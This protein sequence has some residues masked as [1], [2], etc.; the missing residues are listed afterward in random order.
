MFLRRLKHLWM[1]MLPVLLLVACGG[2]SAPAPTGLSVK[3]GESSALVHW[4]ME[5]GVEYWLFYAPKSVAPTTT[6]MSRGWTG[7]TGGNVVIRVQSPTTVTGLSNDIEYVF[8][9]NGRTN[10]GPGGPGA[11]L[12]SATPRLAGSDWA[13]TAAPIAP[14]QPLRAVAQGAL[15]VAGGTSGTLITSSDLQVWT[16]RDQAAT[17]SNLNAGAFLT[18]YRF[19]GDNGTILTSTDAINWTLQAS[20]TS[21]NLYGIGTNN[22]NTAVAVGAN[23]TILTSIDGLTWAS[24]RSNTQ[25]DL[26]GVTYSSAGS[27]LWIAVGA[28]GTILQSADALTWT[29]ID[30][31]TTADLRGVQY[32]LLPL[33]TGATVATGVFVAVGSNGT[34][35]NSANGTAWTRSAAPTPAPTAMTQSFAQT[36]WNA[37][38]YGR[39][40]V[41]VGA[42]GLVAT[43]LDGIQWR[44]SNPTG[45]TENLLAVVPGPLSYSAVGANATVLVAK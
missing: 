37:V 24:A 39:Q 38:T 9:V 29:L 3:A 19:V 4:D 40:F 8:T 33:A 16:K 6:D 43:S 2:S 28:G 30:A 12:V 22:L 25:R 14:S 21:A 32:A 26:Y 27:G 1:S 17:T 31:G 15:T 42:G 44:A 23:G 34:L 13:L 18:S 11:S 7:L 20:N 5:S 41:A 10:G 35:L 36:Q 45:T